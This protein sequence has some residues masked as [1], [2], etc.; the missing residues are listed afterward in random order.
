MALSS[1]SIKLFD[2]GKE[3]ADTTELKPTEFY[4]QHSF[5]LMNKVLSILMNASFIDVSMLIMIFQS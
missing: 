4:L 1:E 5:S 2:F 3:I